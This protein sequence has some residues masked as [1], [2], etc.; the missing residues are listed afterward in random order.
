M[1]RKLKNSNAIMQ[2]LGNSR[3]KRTDFR[4]SN[5]DKNRGERDS[6]KQAVLEPDHFG[7]K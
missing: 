3:E 1:D 6:E 2:N 5:A 4:E 7:A